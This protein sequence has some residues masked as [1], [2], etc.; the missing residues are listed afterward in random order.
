MVLNE[1]VLILDLSTDAITQKTIDEVGSPA[2]HTHPQLSNPLT[3]DCKQTI[4]V[5][6]KH[7]HGRQNLPIWLIQESGKLTFQGYI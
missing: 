5:C 2:S 7:I 1:K 6:E 4:C 3:T